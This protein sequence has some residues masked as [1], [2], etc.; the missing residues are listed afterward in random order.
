[1]DH[2]EK[3]REAAE[4]ISDIAK[5]IAKLRETIDRLLREAESR[6]TPKPRTD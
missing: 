2:K 6:R 1:M 3:L 4:R 5:E